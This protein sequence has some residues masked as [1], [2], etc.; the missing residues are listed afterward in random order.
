MGGREG[1]AVRNA[2]CTSVTI[3]SLA[4]HPFSF[5]D[6]TQ[7]APQL[8][9][10]RQPWDPA[11]CFA[12]RLFA[13]TP[14]DS[15]RRL[16]QCQHVDISRPLQTLGVPRP[17]SPQRVLPPLH[18]APRV[19][20]VPARPLPANPALRQAQV[21]LQLSPWWR[22]SDPDSAA[23]RCLNLDEVLRCSAPSRRGIIQLLRWLNEIIH[24]KRLVLGSVC[25][26]GTIHFCNS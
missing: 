3:G 9:Q 10:M 12:S 7:P 15:P 19:P 13:L 5:P 2:K 24:A 16:P 14:Q 6:P 23:R 20:C 26:A 1:A 25:S 11:Q 22:P 21:G 8:Q 4:C 18:Q 17:S